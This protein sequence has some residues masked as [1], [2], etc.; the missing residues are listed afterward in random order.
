MRQ[1]FIPTL[2]ATNSLGA[3][4]VRQANYPLSDI[5]RRIT[6]TATHIRPSSLYVLEQLVGLATSTPVAIDESPNQTFNLVRQL[7]QW[8][9]LMQKPLQLEHHL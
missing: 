6:R 8:L 5:V 9:F 4:L 2:K 3:Y 1:G 7:R